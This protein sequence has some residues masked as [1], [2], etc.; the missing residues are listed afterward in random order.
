MGLLDE[1]IEDEDAQKKVEAAAALA[2]ERDLTKARRMEDEQREVHER[3]ARDTPT[4]IG[5]HRYV[6]DPDVAIAG[7]FL[8]DI[9]AMKDCGEELD[10]E[11]HVVKVENPILSS[12]KRRA[13]W[14]SRSPKAEKPFVE[15]EEADLQAEMDEG[16]VVIV[17]RR[18]R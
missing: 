16:R 15:I 10:G 4:E 14:A 13:L 3:A 6:G 17:Q 12:G 7:F 9:F 11:W 1:M 2:A 8:G 5:R 18:I